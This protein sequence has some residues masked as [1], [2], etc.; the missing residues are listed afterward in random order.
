ME[1]LSHIYSCEM[2]NKT[3]IR[4]SFENKHTGN[5]SKQVEVFQ[6]FEENMK[7]R[8]KLKATKITKV[9][10]DQIIDPLSCI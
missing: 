6:R 7:N 10:C 8:N 1:D 2:L 3:K 9:Q 4:T 5:I